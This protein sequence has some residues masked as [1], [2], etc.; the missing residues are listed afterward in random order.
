MTDTSAYATRAPAPTYT[1]P[2]PSRRYA[3]AQ[4]DSGDAFNAA[5]RDANRGV[6]REEEP[7]ARRADKRDEDD[8]RKKRKGEGEAPAAGAARAGAKGAPAPLQAHARAPDEKQGKADILS[9][10]TPHP[11]GAQ[12]AEAVQG[13]AG[14]DAVDP[15]AFAQM[16][17]QAAARAET[18][19]PGQT[20]QVR[21]TD[22]RVPLEGVAVTR[23]PDGSLG[24]TLTAGP[25]AT[26]EVS[27]ALET[28]RRRLE[29]RGINLG[30]LKLAE[31]DDL[32]PEAVE[33]SSAG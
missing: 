26:P 28:L 8:K 16:L 33:R 13:P 1:D 17:E 3:P 31:E 21:F 9:G 6:D 27:K 10:L 30:E 19:A 15:A 5:L 24:M 7:S 18:L 23:L 4:S 12:H 25:N 11:G 14:A 32:A 22:L 29:A 20:L 2:A